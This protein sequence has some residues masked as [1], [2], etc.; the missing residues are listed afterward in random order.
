MDLDET[1]VI[2]VGQ[3]PKR[4]APH[5]PGWKEARLM[6]PPN[7]PVQVGPSVMTPRLL[8]NAT[9]ASSLALLGDLKFPDN[10]GYQK[11]H[12]FHD[13]M[14]NFMAK[15][16]YNSDNTELISLKVMMKVLYPGKVKPLQVGVC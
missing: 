8:N 7:V 11:A 14:R 4:H 5:Y 3:I 2:S 15:I 9:P 1:P 6:P 16:A 13:E 10:P 12:Q